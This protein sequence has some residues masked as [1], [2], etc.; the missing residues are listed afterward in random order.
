MA[1]TARIK[2][3]LQ[4]GKVA[5]VFNCGQFLSH[6]FVEII[7]HHGGYDGV[8]IDQEHAPGNSAMDVE[9]A[10]LA[11]SA[12][13]LDSFVRRPAT[14]YASAMAP[15]EAG[16]GGVLFSMIRDADHAEEAMQWVKFRPRGNRGLFGANRDARYGLTPVQ[17]YVTKANTE[18]LVGMQIETQGALDDV[19]KIAKIADLDLV[20]VGPHDLS[21][22]LGVTGEVDHPLVWDAITKVSAECKDAG[23]AW[24]V[25]P[26]DDEYAKRALDLGCQVFLAGHDFAAIH[27]GIQQTLQAY[28]S[29]FGETSG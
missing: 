17:K 20:F 19:G 26:K 6:K 29:L 16:A 9:F 27:A 1:A 18:S 21:Q 12:S 25:V 13:G 8:F 22:V 10:A 5:R 24:G 14:D 28:P 23:V 4:S 11:A 7:G 15:L 2:S 3:L